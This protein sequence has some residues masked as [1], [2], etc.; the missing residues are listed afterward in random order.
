[1]IQPELMPFAAVV[2]QV[3]AW[4]AQRRSGTAFIVSADQRMAQIHLS[5]GK[6]VQVLWRGRRG[7]DAL[8]ALRTLGPASLRFDG[9]CLQHANLREGAPTDEILDYLGGAGTPGAATPFTLA[10]APAAAP[11]PELQAAIERLLLKYIGPIAPIVC[12]D[13]CAQWGEPR[14]LARALAA[15]IPNPEQA[16]RFRA[17]LARLPGMA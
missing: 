14:A 3:R 9:A 16:A 4:C 17:E 7:D 12:A 15:E 5:A 1:M 2:A 8:A 10:D 13:C 11:A 6:I